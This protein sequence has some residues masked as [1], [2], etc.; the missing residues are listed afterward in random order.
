MRLVVFDF[1]GTLVD[2][3]AVKREMFF[4]YSRSDRG[5]VERMRHLLGCV[6]GD[7]YAIWDAY[8]RERDGDAYDVLTVRQIVREFSAAVN[9][10]IALALEIPGASPLLKIL[11]TSGIHLAVSSATPQEDLISVLEQRAWI[12]RFDSIS[13]SPATKI[14]TLKRLSQTYGVKA[15]EIAVVGDG[16]DDLESADLFGC[17]FY[18]VGEG[19]GVL[20]HHKIYNLYELSDV[21]ISHPRNFNG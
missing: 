21:L 18:P 4:T 2:S 17:M 7:R 9:K 19:R 20:P 3:N 13:G 14:E 1:D 16:H 8:V 5:G 6:T 10:A 11:G 12:D 15:E